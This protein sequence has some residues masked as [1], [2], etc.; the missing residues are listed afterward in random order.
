MDASNKINASAHLLAFKDSDFLE[1]EEVRGMRMQLELLKT[2]LAFTEQGIEQTIVIFGSARIS[3]PNN[4]Y[5]I[6]ARKL[7]ALITAHYMNSS[8]ALI[9]V[10]GGGAGIMEAVNR[11]AADMGGQ[12]AGLNIALPHEQTPNN[13]ITPALCF[14]FEHF[15]MRKM[16]FFMRAKALIVFPGGFGTLDELF[17]ALTLIQTKK[18]QRI[19]VILFDKTYWD[20]VIN[21]DA[22]LDAGMILADDLSFIQYAKTSDEAWQILMNSIAENE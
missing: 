22:L 7:S 20:K 4:N 6:E 5:Y 2:N 11:G 1:R 12:S 19:P 3:N 10:T 9:V 15:S 18:M 13:Y 17:E 16:Q 14:Q 21:F 8:P